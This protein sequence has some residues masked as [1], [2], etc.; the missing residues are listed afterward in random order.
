MSD[1]CSLQS[2]HA[3]FDEDLR[4]AMER[5]A[6]QTALRTK[7]VNNPTLLLVPSEETEENEEGEVANKSEKV[8][9]FVVFFWGGATTISGEGWGK[10][11]G[12][13]IIF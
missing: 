9:K 7:W 3:T 4:H 2:K 11:G 6:F 8:G 10:D 12:G 1:K 5:T 13:G